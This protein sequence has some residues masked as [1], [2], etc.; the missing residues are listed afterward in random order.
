MRRSC[1]VL[2][3]FM[4]PTLGA[5]AAPV[6][7][8]Y[9]PVAEDSL[10]AAR[11]CKK[12][13]GTVP[14]HGYSDYQI[15][16]HTYLLT[17][18]GFNPAGMGPWRYL[19]HEE[20]IEMA[21]DYVLYRAAELAKSKGAG[22]FAI[23]HRDDSNETWRVSIPIYDK[24]GH[25]VGHKE[26]IMGFHPGARVLIRLLS[27]DSPVSVR[28]DN[29]V[30]EVGELLTAL[31]KGNARLAAQLVTAASQENVRA[32]KSQFVRWRAP[33]L[34]EDTALEPGLAK[35]DPGLERRNSSFLDTEIIE[36]AHGVFTLVQWSRL[37]LSPIDLLR[38]CIKI[39]DRQGYPVFEL[40]DWTTA[41]YRP[42][43]SWNDWNDWSA[44]FR[45]KARLVLQ[46]QSEPNSLDPVFVV[47]EI[48]ENVVR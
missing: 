31:K 40:E 39:A 43:R 33:V 19:S 23:L 32:S 26:I 42:G 14:R 7:P 41:E 12:C 20:W 30:H 8:R 37:P 27:G 45:T 6:Y 2:L 46:H 22:K 16:E 18:Q 36:D 44:W 17:Y 3:L 21:H 13:F 15:D 47:D 9:Q 29:H 34:I 5:C 10:G 24:Y 4:L 38:E 25:Y 1:L 48:R 35:L 28:S 11:L